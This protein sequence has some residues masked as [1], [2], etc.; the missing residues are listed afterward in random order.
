MIFSDLP[1]DFET[2][3]LMHCSPELYIDEGAAVSYN[4]LHLTVQEYLAAFHLSQ[5]PVENQITCFQ[6]HKLLKGLNIS[7]Q[8]NTRF[9]MVLLFLCGLRKFSGYPSEVL[10]TLCVVKLDSQKSFNV[11]V[12]REIIDP[13]HWL[14]EAHD[15]DVIAGVLG[16]GDIHHF[17]WRSNKFNVVT[18]FDYFVLGYCVSHSKCTWRLDLKSCHIGDEEVEMLV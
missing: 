16:S 10:S 9:H 15:N 2:L 6:Q 3:G 1:E 12:V 13:F 17:S 7:G 11:S 4:F 8:L 18:P 14:F 5:Q